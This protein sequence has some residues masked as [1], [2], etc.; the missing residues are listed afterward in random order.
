MGSNYEYK[1]IKRSGLANGTNFEK[2]DYVVF[3]ITNSVVFED[4]YNN[5]D[6]NDVGE[7]ENFDPYVD[8]FYRELKQFGIAKV[9]PKKINIRLKE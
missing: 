3:N 6:N 7:Y 9:R 5:M 1:L 8:Q 4:K 2:N